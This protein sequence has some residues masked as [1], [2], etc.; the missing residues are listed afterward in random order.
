[1]SR[2]GNFYLINLAAS[3]SSA[4]RVEVTFK[5]IMSNELAAKSTATFFT[6][7]MVR[8]ICAVLGKN[9]CIEPARKYLVAS[10]TSKRFTLP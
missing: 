10:P 4:V 7:L 5:K 8:V 6:L 9:F 1:M 2:F 3:C